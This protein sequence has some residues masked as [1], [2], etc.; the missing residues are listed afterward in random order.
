MS[1]T[2]IRGLLQGIYYLCYIHFTMAMEIVFI[3]VYYFAW[4]IDLKINK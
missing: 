1:H 3:H 4:Y 2:G